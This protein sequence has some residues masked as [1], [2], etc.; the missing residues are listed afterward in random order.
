MDAGT[1]HG[2]YRPDGQAGALPFRPAPGP[3]DADVQA[4]VYR[5]RRRILR[6][7]ER[8]GVLTV[9]T[10]PS[11]G[12]LTMTGDEAMGESDPLLAR[13]LGAAVTGMPPAGPA[14]KRA[15]VRLTV[16]PGAPAQ[17][18][19]RL[20]A[21]D[22]G[23]NLHAA[24]RVAADDR[25]GRQRLCR[26]VLRPPVANDHLRMLSDGLVRVELKRP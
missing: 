16:A 23:F 4:V 11:D 14:Q 3:T 21:Q 5:A 7:L 12:E 2:V 19:G 8:R 13:L 15:P 26:Y 9:T 17:V 20:C 22:C 24:S 6:Y 1:G 10:A 18:K 25:A